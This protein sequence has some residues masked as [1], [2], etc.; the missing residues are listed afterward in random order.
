MPPGGDIV[1]TG[2]TQAW[3]KQRSREKGGKGEPGKEDLLGWNI[4]RHHCGHFLDPENC[5]YRRC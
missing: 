5:I 1:G 3:G 2:D 4:S